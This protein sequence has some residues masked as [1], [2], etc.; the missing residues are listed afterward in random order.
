[1]LREEA[2]E[3]EERVIFSGQSKR[4]RLH[5]GGGGTEPEKVGKV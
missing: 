4:G 1:M 5:G 2:T 3:L